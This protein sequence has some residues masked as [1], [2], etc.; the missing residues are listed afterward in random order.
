MTAF[1]RGIAA[2][3]ALGGEVGTLRGLVTDVASRFCPEHATVFD[4]DDDR[5][6][7]VGFEP[8]SDGADAYAFQSENSISG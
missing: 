1:V 4:Q 3:P 2:P 5:I 7:S 8:V 6:G